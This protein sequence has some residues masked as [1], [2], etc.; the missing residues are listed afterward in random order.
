[1]DEVKTFALAAM[2]A[3]ERLI[4]E[5][6]DVHQYALAMSTRVI[7]GVELDPMTAQHT[8]VLAAIDDDGVYR[9]LARARPVMPAANLSSAN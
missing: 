7:F 3:F 6:S 9:V 4:A 5:L 1:M 8:V 2:P